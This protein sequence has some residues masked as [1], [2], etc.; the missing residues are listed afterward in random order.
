MDNEYLL[1][2]YEF[3]FTQL[4]YY[5]DRHSATMKYIFTLASAVGTAQFAIYKLLG[6][7]TSSFYASQ[8]FL[9]FIVFIAT[10]LLVMTMLQNRLYFVFTSRQ[11]NAIRKYLMET[12]APGFSDNQLYTST[13]FPAF[14]PRSVQ[15]FQLLGAAAISALFAGSCAYA[16]LPA[17]KHHASVSL[18]IA[19]T[20][21]VLAVEGGGGIAYL[22]SVGRKS[23]DEAVHGVRPGRQAR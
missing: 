12:A 8:A 3:N 16:L 4:R 1:K 6:S 17:V 5:D 11:L 22:L 18:T 23:A 14:Q 15:T 7:A 2:E 10:V 9:S 19:T 20:L 13:E 21:V